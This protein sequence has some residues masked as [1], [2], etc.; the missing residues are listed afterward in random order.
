MRVT[1]VHPAGFNFMPGQPDFAML[2]NR[3][4][5]VG[6]MQLAAW[7]EK[8]RFPFGISAYLLARRPKQPD[9]SAS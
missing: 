1:L 3:M 7:L 6:I 4:A 8:H 5:P 9:V 2:A